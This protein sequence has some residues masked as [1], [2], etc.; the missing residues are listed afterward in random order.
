MVT[1]MAKIGEWRA[2]I[3]GTSRRRRSCTRA[4]PCAEAAPANVDAA[5]AFAG[6]EAWPPLQAGQDV[7]PPRL[8]RRGSLC[9]VTS[10]LTSS[11]RGGEQQVSSGLLSGHSDPEP[12]AMR[13]GDELPLQRLLLCSPAYSHL[14]SD[15][16]TIPAVGTSTVAT[17]RDGAA[18]LQD[19]FMA[20]RQPATTGVALPC[21]VD[22]CAVAGEDSHPAAAQPGDANPPVWEGIIDSAALNTVRHSGR[23][24]NQPVQW[25][26]REKA[27]ALRAAAYAARDSERTV[28]E[29]AGRLGVQDVAAAEAA[30]AVAEE[31][32]AAVENAE[33]Q[34]LR[35]RED[36]DQLR[37]VG[38]NGTCKCASKCANIR[39]D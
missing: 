10:P 31:A 8:H 14:D 6:E 19:I 28:A 20:R 9:S 3:A 27:A 7:L 21:A 13:T 33:A 15:C 4:D 37:C 35:E 17:G 38:W 32:A 23:G 30:A 16:S 18:S 25:I 29:S 24:C 12:L 2:A 11:A 26:L 36:C 34:L 5:A 22:S 1:Y 39:F